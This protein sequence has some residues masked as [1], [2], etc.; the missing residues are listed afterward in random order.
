MEKLIEIVQRYP[1]LYDTNHADYSKIKLKEEVWGSIAEKLHL[2]TQAVKAQWKSLRHCHRDAL[3]RRKT[4]S[5]QTAGYKK[6][7][8]YERHMEYLLPFMNSKLTSLETEIFS[9]NEQSNI[10]IQ[11]TKGEQEDETA[12]EE[13]QPEIKEELMIEDEEMVPQTR[14]RRKMKSNVKLQRSVHK[15]RDVTRQEIR[16][17]RLKLEKEQANALYQFFISMYNSTRMLPRHLQFK[18]KRTLFEAVSNAEEQTFRNSYLESAFNN[19]PE[20]FSSSQSSSSAS[21]LIPIADDCSTNVQIAQSSS[22]VE[23]PTEFVKL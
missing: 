8:A 13:E 19:V 3:R 12:N 1:I 21:E 23:I 18:I 4:R 22:F 2:T 6:Y 11:K 5:G 9:S 7:W 14:K 10:E 15:K 16:G 17:K 20:N